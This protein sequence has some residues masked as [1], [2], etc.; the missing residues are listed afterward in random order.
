MCN[1]REKT[2]KPKI[3]TKFNYYLNN[4]IVLD[5]IFIIFCAIVSC[6]SLQCFV[7]I[8]VLRL[9]IQLTVLLFIVSVDIINIY[10]SYIVY[11]HRAR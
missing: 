9:R 7:K 11:I 4:I 10:T 3:Q 1:L 6:T 5:Y 2:T 8:H